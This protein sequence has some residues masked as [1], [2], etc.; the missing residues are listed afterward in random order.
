VN[1]FVTDAPQR[2]LVIPEGGLYLALRLLPILQRAGFAA[3]VLCLRGDPILRSRYLAKALITDSQRVL[4]KRLA[5]ILANPAR[6][7][8]QV[9]VVEEKLARRMMATCP[10]DVLAG[11]QPGALD[12]TAREF[13]LSKFGLVGAR[14]QWGLPIPPSR[15]CETLREVLAFGDETGWPIIVKPPDLLGG[16]GVQRLDSAD[17]LRSGRASLHYPLLAQHFI[18]GR[19]GVVDLVCSRGRPLAWLASH[20]IRKSAGGLGPSS[21]RLFRAMPA[22]APVVAAVAARTGFEGFCGFDWIEEEGTGRHWL[23]EFHPRPPSGFRFGK[24]CGVDFAVA[25]RD[26]V[27]GAASEPQVQPPGRAV[28]A[29]YFAVDLMR[30]VRERDWAALK[31]W[32]PWSGARHDVYWDDWPVLASRAWERLAGRW[33]SRPAS[34]AEEYEF[35]DDRG[36]GWPG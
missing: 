30:C 10:S 32:L 17:A 35:A 8:C 12:A 7:W 5:Q 20:S 18:R 16:A 22:L 21:A 27:A 3:D 23:T 6:S 26:W 9:I 33:K 15:V 25:A 34:M 2:V 4:V 11:W 14:E 19:P 24:Y 1:G 36:T 28:A 29:H 31:A 13:F